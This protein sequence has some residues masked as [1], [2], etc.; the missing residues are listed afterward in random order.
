MVTGV[1]A[2]R[3]KKEK[4]CPHAPHPAAL[5]LTCLCRLPH[6]LRRWSPPFKGP[7]LWLGVRPVRLAQPFES[8]FLQRAEDRVHRLMPPPHK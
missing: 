1:T 3:V 2:A 7:P 5:G 4:P 6:P 8:V